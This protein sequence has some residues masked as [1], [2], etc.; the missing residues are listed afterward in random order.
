MQSRRH[1]RVRELLIRAMG[2][3]IRRE[4]PIN[5]VGLVTVNDIGLS[6]DLHTARVFVSILGP[7][8]QQRNGLALLHRERKRLQALL[9]RAVV[10]KYIP[11]LQFE[12]DNSVARGDR[13]LGIIAE[14]ERSGLGE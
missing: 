4:C 12:L 1:Q 8:A 11:R 13:V 10:L 3:V 6:G 2:E 5:E 7:E 14:L 9:S